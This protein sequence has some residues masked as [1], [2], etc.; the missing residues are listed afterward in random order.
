MRSSAAGA[1]AAGA[2]AKQQASSGYVAKL[3]QLVYTFWGRV[4]MGQEVASGLWPV[5]REWLVVSRVG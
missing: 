2:E 4:A 1:R 3:T 5:R